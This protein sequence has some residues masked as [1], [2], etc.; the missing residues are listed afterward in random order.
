MFFLPTCIS[1]EDDCTGE[2]G[3]VESA[4]MLRQVPSHH[5]AED[6]AHAGG[7]VEVSHHQ[8]A[9]CLRDQVRQQRSADGQGV[10]EQP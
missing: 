3:G 6:E 1:Q 5:R 8:G 9:L 7:C 10:L 2:G 4:L